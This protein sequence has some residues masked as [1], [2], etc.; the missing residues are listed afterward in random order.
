[1]ARG[2]G[3]GPARGAPQLL[4]LVEARIDLEASGSETPRPLPPK[5]NR[6]EGLPDRMLSAEDVNII[7][8][9]EIDFRR[10][11]KVEVDPKTIRKL[12]ANHSTNALIP[13]QVSRQEQLFALDDL[14]Q[15][16]LIFD[17]QARELY[18][19]IQVKGEP[20][21]L[22]LF[23][24]KVHNAWLIRN[25]A[26]SGCHGGVNAGKFFLHRYGL[27]SPKTVY[28]NLLI[29]ERTELDGPNKLIDYEDPRKSLLVQYALPTS[30]ATFKHPP[31]PG[32]KPAFPSGGGK[33][34]SDTLEFIEA[35]YRP[36][37][38]YP[39][40]YEP[41]TLDP[42]PQAPGAPRITR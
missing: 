40:E 33:T 22:N 38:Y 20:H 6:T 37:P 7:R 3:S 26:T 1:M 21:S 15:V 16:K 34:M 2:L 23:R 32:F 17:V 25:C 11:P 36:R 8:V 14:E 18:P 29:L 35:M 9:Y 41:P 30:E 42:V 12:I 39:V 4:E 19:E 24:T 13:D 10:P 28:E 31:V 5:E 27:N